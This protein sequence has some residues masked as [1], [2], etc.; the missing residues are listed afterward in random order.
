M[1]KKAVQSGPV[2]GCTILRTDSCES[3][4]QDEAYGKRVR[5]F[6]VGKGRVRC[7]VCG[8]EVVT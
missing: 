8:H 4:F 1:K 5:V 2:Q 3:P 6:N 7:T